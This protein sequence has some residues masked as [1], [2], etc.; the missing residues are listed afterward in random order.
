MLAEQGSITSK[1]CRLE[2][3]F[4]QLYACGWLTIDLGGRGSGRIRHDGE[5]ARASAHGDIPAEVAADKAYQV[6]TK[7]SDRQNA[8]IEHDG[9]PQRVMMELLAGHTEPFKPFSDD[10]GFTEWL[11]DTN[12]QSTYAETPGPSL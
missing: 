4:P 10:P 2:H 11:S 1:P 8:R 6:A 5:K 12:F 9:A 3:L 7:N